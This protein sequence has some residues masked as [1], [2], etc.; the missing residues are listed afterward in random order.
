MCNVLMTSQLSQPTFILVGT[1]KFMP[2]QV[3]VVCLFRII[4]ASCTTKKSFFVNPSSERAIGSTT[5]ISGI[6]CDGW[7]RSASLPVVGLGQTKICRHAHH[8]RFHQ[9]FGHFVFSIWWMFSLFL[10]CTLILAMILTVL[11][12]FTISFFINLDSISNGCYANPLAHN[13]R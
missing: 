4:F 9:V 2:Y 1:T 12:K 3:L 10:T 7:H 11:I 8:H 13:I 6:F 5:T